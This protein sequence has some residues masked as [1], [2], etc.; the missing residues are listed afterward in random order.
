MRLS[1]RLPVRADHRAAGHPGPQDCARCCRWSACSS[2]CSPWWWCRPA[3]ASPNARMLAD[4]ELSQGIDGTKTIEHARRRR[5]PP[6]SSSD[7]VRGRTDAVGDARRQR[8]SSA[9]PG[10][11]PVNPGG[12]AVRRELGRRPWSAT[13][14]GRCEHERPAPPGQAIELRLTALTGDVR[15]FRPF[16][17]QSAASGSTSPPC[18]SMAP[19]L[20]L[21]EEA[22]KGFERYQV[23]AE[24][25][26]G[27]AT[28][29]P[30]P[31]V[32]RRG[33]RRRLRSRARTCGSTS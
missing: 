33:R 26:V 16:R 4:L 27:G 12:V 6:T 19:R 32:R 23:P 20:V 1:G 29:Q 21:N 24:M 25:R 11:Q 28:G 30:H 9:S 17:P 31:A 5:R 14:T 10:V 3:P 22:A 2:A 15:P 18:P 8:R 13:P 7:T